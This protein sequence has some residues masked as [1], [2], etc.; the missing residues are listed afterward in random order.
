MLQQAVSRANGEVWGVNW[1]EQREQ[2]VATVGEVRDVHVIGKRVGYCSS[3]GVGIVDLESMTEVLRSDMKTAVR[4][5]VL[6]AH[7]ATLAVATA[8]EVLILQKKWVALQ[9]TS[10]FTSPITGLES[11]QHLLAILSSELTLISLP[12]LQPL[13]SLPLFPQAVLAFTSEILAFLYSPANHQSISLFSPTVTPNPV[14]PHSYGQASIAPFHL[15]WLLVLSLDCT[16]RML[17][18]SL[19]VEFSM[20][21]GLFGR[22]VG[23]IGAGVEFFVVSERGIEH[24]EACSEEEH[25]KFMINNGYFDTAIEFIKAKKEGFA[26]SDVLKL[27]NLIYSK[28]GQREMQ[29]FTRKLIAEKM[30]QWE[31]LQGA[32][33]THPILLSLV[34]V[35]IPPPNLD[36]IP[37]PPLSPSPPNLFS[38]LETA[39]TSLLTKRSVGIF[40]LL[41]T[42]HADISHFLRNLTPTQASILAEIDIDKAAAV[43]FKRWPEP[44][45]V[46][47]QLSSDLQYCYYLQR[48]RLGL[49]CS[50]E[51]TDALMEAMIRR[52]EALAVDLLRNLHGEKLE[53]ALELASKY[54]NISAKVYLLGR[55]NRSSEVTFTLKSDL[56]AAISY[57]EIHWNEELW[58]FLL[59]SHYAS[60]PSA[61]LPCL[62][63]HPAA[64]VLIEQ[65]QASGVCYEEVKPL[66]TNIHNASEIL[67]NAN[68]IVEK[69]RKKELK[70]VN[71]AYQRGF[72]VVSKQKCDICAQSLGNICTFRYCNHHSH[73]SCTPDSVCPLCKD[74]SLIVTS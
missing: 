21:I 28:Q 10:I 25:I 60:L 39:I 6:E 57:L 63:M 37:L 72:Y 41:A 47:A 66:L 49:Q 42:S 4:I 12:S 14:L 55:L 17:N 9:S 26:T 13:Y 8:T 43:V 56:K 46:F 1:R 5:R 11:H 65:V 74:S 44:D 70:R 18:A 50:A 32:V 2:R 7:Y 64:A 67:K 34:S 3:G 40:D 71:R 73:V 62:Y 52:K 27:I 45:L 36:Q 35:P 19:E 30:I 53:I 54:N 68:K 48:W 31:D 15:Y 51:A 24:F 20:K 16:L 22:I 69:E 59:S 58:D 23:G 38:S 61:T 29:R 33:S